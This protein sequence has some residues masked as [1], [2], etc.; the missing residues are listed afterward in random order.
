M[1]TI[2]QLA[3]MYKL[4]YEE[5]IKMTGNTRIGGR[6]RVVLNFYRMIANLEKQ[7][8]K[9]ELRDNELCSAY[10]GFAAYYKRFF[11]R[12]Y[13]ITP[14]IMIVGYKGD[15]CTD[16]TVE[17]YVKKEAE[18]LETI[19]KYINGVYAIDI[20]DIHPRFALQTLMSSVKFGQDDC[21]VLGL[22]NIADMLSICK[23]TANI[24]GISLLGKHTSI[25][26]RDSLAGVMEVF[27]KPEEYLSLIGCNEI[28]GIKGY[29][30]KKARGIAE[31]AFNSGK[32][33]EDELKLTLSPEDFD[34]YKKNYDMLSFRNFYKPNPDYKLRIC[35]QFVNLFD[36]ESLDRL[37]HEYFFLFPIDTRVLG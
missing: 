33:L 21:F 20:G 1:E 8:E 18:K 34:I 27:A 6:V 37:N 35:S 25:M 7:A 17:E 3:T 19:S 11:E 5:L 16:E 13:E 4:R 31:R 23:S 28:T 32:K 10:L 26:D 12:Y 36:K 22:S 30:P 29:G 9:M 14:E 2:T 15:I 24:I